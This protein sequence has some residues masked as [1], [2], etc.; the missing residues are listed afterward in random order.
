MSPHAGIGLMSNVEWLNGWPPHFFLFPIVLGSQL[1]NEDLVFF[2]LL[3]MVIFATFSF[4][5]SATWTAF[6]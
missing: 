6:G 5:P 2:L 4:S 3:S 1:L